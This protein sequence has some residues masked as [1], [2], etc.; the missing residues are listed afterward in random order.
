MLKEFLETRASSNDEDIFKVVEEKSLKTQTETVTRDWTYAMMNF[1]AQRLLLD[2]KSHAKGNI[3]LDVA[4]QFTFVSFAASF[5]N[6]IYVESRN[7]NISFSVPHICD[8]SSITCEAQNLPISDESID[9]VTS[10][11]AIEHFGLGRYGDTLDYQGD[12]NG[13]KEFTRVLKKGGFL[14]TGVPASIRSKIEFN[15]QRVYNPIEFDSMVTKNNVKKLLGVIVYPPHS[16]RDGVVI[17]NLDSLTT[18]PENHT[19]PV[20]LSVYEK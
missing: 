16:R 1:V 17:G 2:I 3:L 14:M 15:S 19:P 7:N 18:F 5:Y 10:L 4:S 13:I 11:H 12:K 8:F 9:V 20:Y 6:V